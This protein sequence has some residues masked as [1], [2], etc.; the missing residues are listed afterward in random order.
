MFTM[1]F[2]QIKNGRRQT[3]IE[4]PGKTW[5]T[6]YLG[7][8]SSSELRMTALRE[9]VNARDIRVNNRNIMLTYH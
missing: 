8:T 9:R 4:A 6:A 2:T 7:K 3:D 1:P 5:V